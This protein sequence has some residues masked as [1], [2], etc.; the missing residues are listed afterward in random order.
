VRDD[1][2]VRFVTPDGR[3]FDGTLPGHTQPLGDWRQLIT[4][5]EDEGIHIDRHTAA[6]CWDGEA[7]DYSMAIDALLRRWRQIK[8]LQ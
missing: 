7:C 4:Q 5:H 2:A 8:Q 3:S 6:T 1:G